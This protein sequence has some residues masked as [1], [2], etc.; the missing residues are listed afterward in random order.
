MGLKTCAE[1]HLLSRGGQ[2]ELS[3]LNTG[4]RVKEMGRE[5]LIIIRNCFRKYF[6]KQMSPHWSLNI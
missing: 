3:I 1:K 2:K 4:M 6:C 5:T